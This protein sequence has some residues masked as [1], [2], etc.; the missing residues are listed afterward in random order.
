MG[1]TCPRWYLSGRFTVEQKSPK[2]KLNRMMTPTAFWSCEKVIP[3]VPLAADTFATLRMSPWTWKPSH[4]PLTIETISYATNCL[5]QPNMVAWKCLEK[6]HLNQM[7]HLW[8]TI[9]FEIR[10]N[11]IK[12]NFYTEFSHKNQL[13]LK[14][15]IRFDFPSLWTLRFFNVLARL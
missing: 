9:S 2:G 1:K 3:I 5:L 4:D 11:L 12:R 6:S 14:E 10:L 7:N 8:I 13:I 15:N